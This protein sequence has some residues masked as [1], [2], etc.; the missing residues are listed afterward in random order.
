MLI[1]F[2][3]HVQP[4]QGK[5]RPGPDEAPRATSEAPAS[6]AR[7]SEDQGFGGRAVGGIAA[8]S[9]LGLAV[10]YL[11]YGQPLSPG[12]L[13]PELV[14]LL[15]L[16]AWASVL[17]AFARHAAARSERRALERHGRALRSLLEPADTAAG[18]TR[19]DRGP[20]V[21]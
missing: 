15:A 14:V 7:T 12:G 13:A 2:A 21:H 5:G 16:G 9:W 1:A 18:G 4:Q 17:A 10:Y 11:V 6:A 20:T 19:R 3:P 8:A